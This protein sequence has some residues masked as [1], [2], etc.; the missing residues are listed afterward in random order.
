MYPSLVG[1]REFLVTILIIG[2]S[3]PS[4]KVEKMLCKYT[5]LNRLSNVMYIQYN[6]KFAGGNF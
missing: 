6:V 3:L 4:T 1:K 5:D 2:T